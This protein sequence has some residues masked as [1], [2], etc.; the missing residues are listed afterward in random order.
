MCCFLLRIWR[1]GSLCNSWAFAH[2]DIL[3]ANI[4]ANPL[5]ELAPRLAE[6]VRVGGDLVLSGILGEQAAAVRTA[7][8]RWFS[9]S[10][11]VERDGW[12]CLHG[13]RV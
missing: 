6:L 9:L 3:L 8:E 11:T 5:I 4:L 10:E 12:V 2:F 13:I 7:Y 1:T